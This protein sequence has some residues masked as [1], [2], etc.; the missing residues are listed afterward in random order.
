MELRHVRYFVAV[1]EHQHFGRAAEALHTAQPSLSQQVRQ[2][3]R[4]IGVPL[5][6]RTTRKLRLTPAG[7]LFLAESRQLLAHVTASVERA[8]AV[9]KGERGL[10]SVTFVSGAMGAGALPHLMHD[11]Q[12]SHP[13][14]AVDVRPMPAFTQIE[15]LREGHVHVGFFS[16]GY[17]EEAFGEQFLWRERLVLAVPE[18]HPFARKP[19]LR[20]SDLRDG[21]LL[22]Y[23]RS[24]GSQLQ[25]GIIA[26]LHE[27]RIEPDFVYQGADAET[28]VGLVAAGRGISLVP[29]SWNVFR[30]PGVVYR[31]IE[32][33]R[34]IEPGMSMYWNAAAAS[35]LVDEFVRSARLTLRQNPGIQTLEVSIRQ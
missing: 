12:E 9:A 17:K 1:A 6:E 19:K 34:W 31:S 24:S 28:I 25:N 16:A 8:R 20:F 7:E 21:R 22:L 15:S 5:F 27:L 30:F 13:D 18:S 11:F 2:L 4:E 10:L 33:A 32:P 35:P 14:V 23:S 3:E 26:V 29:Q